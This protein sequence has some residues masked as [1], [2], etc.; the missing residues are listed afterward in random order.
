MIDFRVN[1]EK[2]AEV[3]PAASDFFYT[4][5]FRACPNWSSNHYSPREMYILTI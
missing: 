5:S 2:V 1:L 4:K 3:S